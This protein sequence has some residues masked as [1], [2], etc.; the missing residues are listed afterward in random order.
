MQLRAAGGA[1]L[2]NKKAPPKQGFSLIWERSAYFGDV[3]S[4]RTFLAL[5]YF[6]FDFI[7]LG[8]RLETRSTYRAEMDKDVRAALA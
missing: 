2:S 6:E 4:L 7:T 3:G 5:N 8:E 1:F